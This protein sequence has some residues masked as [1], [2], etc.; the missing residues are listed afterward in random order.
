MNETV[1]RGSARRVLAIGMPINDAA[2]SPV[3][4]LARDGMLILMESDPVRADDARRYFSSAGFAGRATVIPGDPRRMLYKLSGPFD[5]IF[6][7][8]D[9]LSSR[10]V[11]EKL[12]AP[13]GVLIANDGR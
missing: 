1:I 12:L 6:C 2:A 10:H 4:A 5:V 11:I 7:H 8:D 13:D 9:Y 3:D